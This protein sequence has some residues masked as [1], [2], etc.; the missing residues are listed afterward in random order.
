MSTDVAAPVD[1]AVVVHDEPVDEEKI[2]ADLVK[3]VTKLL[4]KNEQKDESEPG[5]SPEKTGESPEDPPK[6]ESEKEK[7]E[8]SAAAEKSIGKD[9]QSRAKEAGLSEALAE[10]LH[11]S[12]QLEETLAAIDRKMIDF[13]QSRQAPKEDPKGETKE[14]KD[15]AKSES[16][17]EVPALD[18]ELFDEE[19]VKRDAYQQKRIDALEAKLATVLEGQSEGFDEWFDG[20]LSELGMDTTDNAKCQAV[21]KTFGAVCDAFGKSPTAKNADMVRRAYT[22]TYPDEV[23]KQKSQQTVDRLRDASGKFL[24]P[25]KTQGGPPTK[26]KTPEERHD[27][28]VSDVGAYLKKQGVE[29]SGV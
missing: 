28:L 26:P 27:K 4:A 14:P 19:L 21:F 18:P 24:T 5:D 16:D 9:L 20:Q 2:H 29:M 22:A 8:D 23:I 13:V 17:Q 3:D 15:D 10:K 25:S 6:G 11:Q 1:D 7:P 12:G